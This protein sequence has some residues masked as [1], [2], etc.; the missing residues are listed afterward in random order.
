MTSLLLAALVV[1]LLAAR[2]DQPGAVTPAE[3]WHLARA[4]GWWAIP[5]G[6]GAL[7]CAGALVAGWSVAGLA[8]LAARPA[9]RLVY[10]ASRVLLAV[11]VVL[12]AIASHVALLFPPVPARQ[13]PA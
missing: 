4:Y 7:L 5:R 8:L 6:I 3:I 9:S 13:E 11:A 1:T 12:A 10:A 2:R